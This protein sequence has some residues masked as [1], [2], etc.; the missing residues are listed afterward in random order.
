MFEAWFKALNAY[1]YGFWSPFFEILLLTAVVYGIIY[2]MRGTRG[3]GILRGLLIFYGGFIITVLAVAQF[4]QLE[5]IRW[6]VE[7][8]LA[9][10]IIAVIVVFQPE[11]RRGLIRI[12]ETPVWNIFN[13]NRV[14]TLGEVVKAVV[15]LSKKTIG[16]IIVIERETKL[17]GYIEGGVKLEAAVGS[18]LICTIFHPKTPLHD[19]AVIIR[20]GK[21]VAANCLLPFTEN[22][23]ICRGMGARHRAGIGL[24]EEADAVVIIVSEETGQ[25]SVAIKGEILKNLDAT[26]LQEILRDE[27]A[28]EIEGALVDEGE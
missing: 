2:F 20:K 18:E 25:I 27:C 9:I 24:S 23:E 16:A 6:L 22:T 5:N 7:N 4:A 19:G 12:G 3:A 11:I 10:A 8:L 14:S 26:R 28:L 1:P 21:I 17:G 15:S 13:V